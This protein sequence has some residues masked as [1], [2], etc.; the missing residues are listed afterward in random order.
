MSMCVQ[1]GVRVGN[2][3][4][5]VVQ[6]RHRKPRV[7]Y[8]DPETGSYREEEEGGVEVTCVEGW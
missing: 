6:R 3:A 4:G 5:V 7:R 1:L 8:L 2:T